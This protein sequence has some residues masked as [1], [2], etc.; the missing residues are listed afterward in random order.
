MKVR[1]TKRYKVKVRKRRR[2][3]PPGAGAGAVTTAPDHPLETFG[4][5][6]V[7]LGLGFVDINRNFTVAQVLTP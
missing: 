2:R 6:G 7:A 4:A 5:R 1:I 3:T